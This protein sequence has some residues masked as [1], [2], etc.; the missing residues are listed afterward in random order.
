MEPI[1]AVYCEAWPAFPGPELLKGKWQD[2]WL[3][4]HSS[5]QYEQVSNKANVPRISGTVS[6][7]ST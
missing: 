5:S 1:L 3:Y 7:V 4:Q 6:A 2:G